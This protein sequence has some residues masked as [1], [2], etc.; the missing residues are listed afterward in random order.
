MMS[1]PVVSVLIPLFNEE[2]FIESCLNSIF[3]N[4]YPSEALEVIVIDGGSSDSGPAR[5]KKYMQHHENLILL[6]N[7]EKFVP[8]AMNIGAKHAKGEFIIRTDAHAVYSKNF[9]LR[10]IELM[11]EKNAASV[12]GIRKARGK[13]LVGKSIAAVIS[14]PIG[15]GDA[16]Y[17]TA[18]SSGWVDTVHCGCWRKSDY[19]KIGGFDESWP[20]NQD[21]E[22]NIRLR[23]HIGNL[24][25][26]SEISCEYYVRE[27][28]PALIK[29]YW[30]YGWWRAKT[31]LRYPTQ[32]KARQLIPAFFVFSLLLTILVTSISIVPFAV[33]VSVYL[34]TLV[35]FSLL[36][37]TRSLNIKLMIPIIASIIHFSWGTG[38]LS[39]LIYHFSRN[40]F[41]SKQS[42][43]TLPK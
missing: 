25:L 37:P 31:T 42:S 29:Q 26:S 40:I 32:V 11:E 28:I 34:A 9:I 19:E 35:T 36:S 14:S 43:K 20:V 15:A 10:S 12:G 18:I 38:Y 27:T 2:D 39:G 3:Q 8:F 4:S 23:K 7:L 21:A 22:F 16:F 30:R 5:V 6:D 1:I 13:S 24:Y 17:Q 33:L 41:S